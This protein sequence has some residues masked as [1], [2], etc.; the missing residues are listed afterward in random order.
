MPQLSLHSPVGDLTLSEEHGR[1]VS[2][3]WGW[4]PMQGRSRLLERARDQLNEYF[5]GQRLAFDL[6]LN[7]PGSGYQQRVWRAL[8][9]IPAGQTITY[10]ALAEVAGGAARS[11]GGAMAHNPI[12][13]IIPCHRVVA[14]TGLGGYSGGDGLPTKRFLLA[15]EQR[16][17]GLAPT[18]EP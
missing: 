17:L 13:I 2:L 7:P 11:I 10:R 15:L 18:P 5:D 1:I 16:A 3:D 12:P 4:S 9:A 8:L 6:M 14:T